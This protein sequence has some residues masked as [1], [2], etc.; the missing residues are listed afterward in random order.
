MKKMKKYTPQYRRGSTGLR[1]RISFLFSGIAD[2]LN[3]SA[4][5][6]RRSPHPVVSSQKPRWL[7]GDFSGKSGLLVVGCL[8][9]AG[10][11]LYFGQ[12]LKKSDIFRLATVAVHGS[13]L[14]DKSTIL[15]LGEIEPGLNLL[16]LNVDECKKRISS[17]PWIAS[18]DIIRSWP[19][20]LTVN[21]HEFRPLAM[22]NIE[23]KQGQGL[24]YIDAKGRIFAKVEKDHELDFPVITGVDAVNDV[25]GAVI[26]QNG[27]AGEAFS[28]IRRAASQANAIMPL[29]TISEVNVSAANGIIVYLVDR[30]FPIYMGYDRVQQKYNLLVKLLDR[31]YRK[32]KIEEIKE[33]RMDYF[34]NRIL[35]AK[36]E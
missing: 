24:Y 31:L 27:L 1:Q 22:M 2:R 8:I 17:H 35:V 14:V 6:K 16:A 36:V 20:G 33:I 10:V 29:Q 34:E 18:V 23:G 3:I 5:F 4:K 11:G 15:D 12:T 13:R 7:I 26:A 32:K 30:P 19:S 21:V 9:L 28:F 25:N